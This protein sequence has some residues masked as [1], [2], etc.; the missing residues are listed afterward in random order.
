MVESTLLQMNGCSFYSSICDS[1]VAD[2][3]VFGVDLQRVDGGRTRIMVIV[4]VG[5]QMV[6][7][8]RRLL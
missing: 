2:G 4:Q 3:A 8:R 6:S 1:P 5:G 7:G